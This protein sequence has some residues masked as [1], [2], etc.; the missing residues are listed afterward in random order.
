MPIKEE[1]RPFKHLLRRFNSKLMPKIK[2]KIERLLKAS[3][4]R[5]A[6]YLQWLSNI[7]PVIK[8][9][10]Q[11]SICIGFCNLNLA[12]LKNEY[13]MPIVVMLVDVIAN[14][15]ILSFMNGY[16][17]YNQIYLVEE[18][19]HKTAFCCP[20]AVSIFEWMVMSFGLENAS[21]FINGQ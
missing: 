10:G 14:N 17:G 9:I 16:F 20:G 19:V 7:V 12:T 21:L 18:D 15:G 6:R 3:F 1:L 11:V 13:V 5:T 2:Q 4:I 8:K